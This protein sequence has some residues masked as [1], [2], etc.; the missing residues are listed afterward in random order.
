MSTSISRERAER[1]A[2]G[3][4][5]DTC[6][7]YTYKKLVV[8][9][10]PDSIR[11]ELAAVWIATMLCGVCGRHQELGLDAEGDVVFVS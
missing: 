10:A 1:I 5:C 2:R 11:D 6:G 4:A 8:K 7:E 9:P 3:H